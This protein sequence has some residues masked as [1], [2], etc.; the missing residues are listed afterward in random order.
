[1]TKGLVNFKEYFNEHILKID[2]EK[3]LDRVMWENYR[4]EYK[5]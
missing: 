2:A 3:E 5:E 1:M 4:S